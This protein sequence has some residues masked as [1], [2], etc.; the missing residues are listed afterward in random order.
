MSRLVFSQRLHGSLLAFLLVLSILPPALADTADERNGSREG[1]SVDIKNFGKVNDHIYR[2]GQPKGDD[3]RKLI[4]LGVKTIVDLR[5]DSEPGARAA[6][7]RA[8]MRYIN[9]PMAPKSYPQAEAAKRFLEIVNDQANGPVYVHCA[10]GRHR[11]GAMLAVYRMEVEGWNIERAYQEM[12]DYDFYTRFGHGCYKD[13]VYDYNRAL[14]TRN[15]TNPA[16]S[17]KTTVTAGQQE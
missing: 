13:Y 15:Q 16:S 2:G 8:G 9:L 5:S 4:E 1:D 11:T 12:K 17:A 7:E 6:A 3:Y 10:G 14:Q